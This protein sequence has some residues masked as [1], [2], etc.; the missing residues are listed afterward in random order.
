MIISANELLE[1]MYGT[2]TQNFNKTQMIAFAIELSKIHSREAIK[3]CKTN[4]QEYI[5]NNPKTTSIN[6]LKEV[7]SNSYP[8]K[9]II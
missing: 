9:N 1:S 4:C 8:V 3:Q 6:K 5:K 7:M 2:K